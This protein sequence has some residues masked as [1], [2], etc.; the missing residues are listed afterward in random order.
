M[1]SGCIPVN[2]Q[3]E[4]LLSCTPSTI[5]S[6]SYEKCCDIKLFYGIIG[7]NPAYSN[8]LNADNEPTTIFPSQR[9]MLFNAL[10]EDSSSTNTQL[11]TPWQCRFDSCEAFLDKLSSNTVRG[12]G[13]STKGR[14]KPFPLNRW[15]ER[16]HVQPMKIFAGI[17]VWPRLLRYCDKKDF[18]SIAKMNLI[19]L[20]VAKVQD[21]FSGGED[22]AYNILFIEWKSRS[23]WLLSM[24]C[25]HHINRSL[26]RH[27]LYLIN[28][29]VKGLPTLLA[30]ASGSVWLVL[31]F[32]LQ[33]LSYQG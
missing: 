2:E 22:F 20:A 13:L 15:S 19:S 27:E 14:E 6:F 8:H 3:G 1:V 33:T 5:F 16:F 28:L 10:C 11:F 30:V 7:S 26:Q 31:M 24:L 23:G 18:S 32:V 9:Q 17:A 25:G 4:L 21:I 29:R 12:V